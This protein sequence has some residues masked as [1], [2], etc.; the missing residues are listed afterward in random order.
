MKQHSLMFEVIA[1]AALSL[2]A[3]AATD[4]IAYA[5]ICSGPVEPDIWA[6]LTTNYQ[7]KTLLSF[8]I[9]PLCLGLVGA[10]LIWV[11]WAKRYTRMGNYRC[12]EE[13]G[14]A[15]WATK[16]EIA[17]YGDE[18]DP[19]N[20]V[21][22]TQHAKIRLQ[23]TIHDPKTET[24]NNVM[25]VGGPGTGKTR[26]YVKPNL[27]Q[28][29]ANYFIT[30][31]KGTLIADMTHVLTKCDYEIKTF[32]TINM[33]Q[34]NKFNPIAYITS[35]SKLMRFVE[36][37]IRNTTGDKDHKGDPFWENSEKLLYLAL[38]AYLLEHCPPEDRNIE[39]LI[40]L[41]SLADASETDESYMSALDWLFWQLETG[42]SLSEDTQEVAQDP[43][44][45]SFASQETEWVQRYPAVKSAEDFAL[46]TYKQFKVAAGK[47]LKS[48]M[49]SCNVRM[50]PFDIK[51]VRELCKTDELCL[52]ELG[53]KNKK[54]AIFASM[55]DTDSTFDFL[56]ALLM[57]TALDE[58]CEVALARHHGKLPRCV[59]FIF[60]EFANIGTIPDFE[61]MVT[62]TRSRNIAISMILQSLSQLEESYGEKNAT[63]IMNACD[64]L[65]F[66]GGKSSETN[67]KISEM[68]GKQTI[69]N[70]TIN[71]SYGSS[72]SYTKNYNII[73]RDLMQPSEVARMPRDEALVLINGAQP[74]RD[75]KYTLRDHPRVK[76][77]KATENQSFDLKNAS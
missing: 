2:V 66:L 44:K 42:K 73:E 33:A 35:E 50:K 9:L 64:T 54:V 74:F 6:I 7:S 34:S 58:L 36:C 41:L 23:D 72:S 68:I 56:F 17:A 30:D 38:T 4:V 75:K 77:L 52:C 28:A 48:I 5:F 13:H 70:M 14:S 20:N 3:F 55:S 31:P 49:I 26:Y 47:T 45:L 12:G 39:S 21:L 60:D 61:R 43:Y 16:K 71:E 25:I 76:A 65:L 40:L 32:D 22:L 11:A 8:E 27:L 10:C 37:L 51:E 18:R 15:R 63:T 24:N 59:H 69:K 67:K 53:E 46:A 19:S 57:Q 1:A 29:N 62:V